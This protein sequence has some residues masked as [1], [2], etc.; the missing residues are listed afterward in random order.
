MLSGMA[1][2]ISDAQP[3]HSKL[4]GSPCLVRS[5]A[6]KCNFV[7]PAW[8]NLPLPSRALLPVA[9][10]PADAAALKIGLLCNVFTD[11]IMT[12]RMAR[13]ESA[14]VNRPYTSR[15]IFAFGKTDCDEQ[16]Y[17]EIYSVS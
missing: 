1:F 17:R 5:S 13:N 12:G 14:T 7:I 8:K 2:A 9:V 3:P 15:K 16:P 4:S 6:A 10:L 11:Y